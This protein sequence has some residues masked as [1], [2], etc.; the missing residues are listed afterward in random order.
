MRPTWLDEVLDIHQRV[1][2]KWQPGTDEDIRFLAL[3]LAGEAGE[4]ANLIKKDW[5]GDLIDWRKVNDKIADIRVYLELLSWAAGGL[6]T[7]DYVRDYALPKIRA[8]WPKEEL[9]T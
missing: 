9:P 3:A 5:R 1:V 8:R 7:D 4:L 6:T 2:K